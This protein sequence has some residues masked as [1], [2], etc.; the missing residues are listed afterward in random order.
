MFDRART[1]IKGGGVA[2]KTL[3]YTH[4]GNYVKNYHGVDKILMN[5]LYSIPGVV[6]YVSDFE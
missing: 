1:P 5:R 6:I 3:K 2:I 4:K